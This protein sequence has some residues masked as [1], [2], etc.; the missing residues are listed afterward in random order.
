MTFSVQ[1]A[2][3]TARLA[4]KLGARVS[5]E[6]ADIPGVGRVASLI[7]PQGVLFSVLAWLAM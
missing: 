3:D 1:S 7:S 5:F 2:D 4:E 6:P